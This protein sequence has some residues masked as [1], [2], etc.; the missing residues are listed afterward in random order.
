ML[1]KDNLIFI[2]QKFESQIAS[3]MQQVYSPITDQNVTE[4]NGKVLDLQLHK[5]TFM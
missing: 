2:K 5:R 3:C 1:L 4:M